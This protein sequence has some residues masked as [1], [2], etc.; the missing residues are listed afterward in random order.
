M[1]CSARKKKVCLVLR[2]KI[3][4]VNENDLVSLSLWFYPIAD[5]FVKMKQ[6][7]TGSRPDVM[8]KLC[9]QYVDSL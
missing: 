4:C 5:T 7:S 1:G 3:H 8:Y 6:V 9:Y 2:N